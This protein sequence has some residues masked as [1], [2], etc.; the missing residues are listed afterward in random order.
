MPTPEPEP[1]NAHDSGD[2]NSDC[3]HPDHYY[4]DDYFS[5]E[6][7]AELRRRIA[8]NTWIPWKDVLCQLD[9]EDDE[10]PGPLTL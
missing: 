3:S 4:D 5:D 7:L 10:R 8:T 9:S 2:C 6:E 1:A